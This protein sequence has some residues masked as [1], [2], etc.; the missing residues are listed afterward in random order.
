MSLRCGW[1]N[2]VQ[3]GQR[4][5]TKRS[6]AQPSTPCEQNSQACF[7]RRKNDLDRL[8]S[9]A[10]AG[11]S[12]RFLANPLFRLLRSL[13]QP[14]GAAPLGAALHHAL[15]SSASFTGSRLLISGA[16][17]LLSFFFPIRASAQARRVIVVKV[18]GLPY[19]MVDRF[20]RDR[21]PQ[22]GKS[23]L[24]WFDY[25]FFQNGSRI[26]H[27]YVRGMSL[28]APSWS[29]IDTGQHLQ[30]KGNVEFDRYTLQTYDYL[31]FIP[32]Y[33]QATIGKRVDMQGV[34]VLD[35]IGVPLLT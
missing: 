4:N 18:D 1:K 6:R 31:D 19:E 16:F 22:T 32:F 8:L 7:G 26:A 12:F 23:L 27:F 3:G 11:L 25:I 24:P 15:N 9:P 20:V 21:D 30:I 29:L 10:K 17:I 14:S 28:S 35:A 13:Q 2:L 5:E 33:V 34:E